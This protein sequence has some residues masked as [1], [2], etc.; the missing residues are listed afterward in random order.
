AF[1]GR[2]REREGFARGDAG[3][4]EPAERGRRAAAAQ[5]AG[6]GDGVGLSVSE[7]EAQRRAGVFCRWCSPGLE[8][9]GARRSREEEPG[10]VL[11]TRPGAPK[12]ERTLPLPPPTSG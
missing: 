8:D 9:S 11:R 5:H 10:S 1:R 6:R 4:P 12:K 2:A 3:V 7:P